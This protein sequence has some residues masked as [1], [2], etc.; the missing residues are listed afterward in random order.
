VSKTVFQ[1]VLLA[2]LIHA[3]T[4]TQANTTAIGTWKTENSGRGYIHVV[5]ENCENKLCGTIHSAFDN[6][7]KSAPAYEHIGKRM[8]WNMRPRSATSWGSGRI[9][10]PTENKTYKSKM[11]ISGDVLSVSGCVLV[12]CKSQKW[13][14]VRQ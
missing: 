14:R 6:E 10:D 3:T 5:I 4:A 1:C 12:F 8:I 13:T 11:S 7:G 2:L 9:W